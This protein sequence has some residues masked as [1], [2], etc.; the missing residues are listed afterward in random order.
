MKKCSSGDILEPGRD[1]SA[2]CGQGTEQAYSGW[3][4]QINGPEVSGWRTGKEQSCPGLPRH[5][6]FFITNNSILKNKNILSIHIYL[7]FYLHFVRF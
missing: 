4:L 7:L 6:I 3:N 1:L 5:D 2:G